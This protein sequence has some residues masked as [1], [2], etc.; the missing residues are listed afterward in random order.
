MRLTIFPRRRKRL[1]LRL[2]L[3]LV[4]ATPSWSVGLALTCNKGNIAI[5]NLHLFL[6]AI[7]KVAE[8]DPSKRLLSLHA[9]KEA[10]YNYSLQSEHSLKMLRF[11][12]LSRIARTVNWNL[13]RTLSGLLFSTILPQ[14]RKNRHETLLL[15]A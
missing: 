10:S 13:S 5:G 15:H 12:R 7:L 4:S 8:H 2:H 11:S 14:I 6:P 3:Q 9:L 1:G